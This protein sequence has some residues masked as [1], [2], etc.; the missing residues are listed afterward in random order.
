MLSK[1][2]FVDSSKLSSIDKA[3][4]TRL[5]QV[6]SISQHFQDIR[7]RAENLLYFDTGRQVSNRTSAP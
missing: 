7:S 2:E 3:S 4:L 6:G 5:V 1:L